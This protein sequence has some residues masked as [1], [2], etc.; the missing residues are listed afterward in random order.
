MTNTL[1]QKAAT[2]ARGDARRDWRKRMSDHVA[3]GLLVYTCLHIFFTTGAM[4]SGSG[5]LLPYFALV[6]L[7]LA[8]IPACRLMEKRWDGLSDEAAGDPALAPAF[9]RDAALVWLGAVGL[10][11]ALTGLFHLARALA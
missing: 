8:I 1:H 10:P 3:F 7:V 11:L 5:S 4:K 9:R 2:R 6:V